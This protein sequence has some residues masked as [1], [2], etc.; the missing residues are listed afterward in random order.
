MEAHSHTTIHVSQSLDGTCNRT[1]TII[2]GSSPLRLAA[3]RG[4]GQ[5]KRQL[6]V[7]LPALEAPG[8]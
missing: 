1:I 5:R 6:P 7:A 3:K 4:A 2:E 8:S